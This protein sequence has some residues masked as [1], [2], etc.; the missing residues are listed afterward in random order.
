MLRK[1]LSWYPIHFAE[2]NGT[3][4]NNSKTNKQNKTKPHKYQLGKLPGF[5]IEIKDFNKNLSQEKFPFQ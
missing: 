1:P 3:A 2:H 4:E 5:K